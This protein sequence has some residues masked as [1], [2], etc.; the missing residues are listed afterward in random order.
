[1]YLCA[2]ARVCG[3]LENFTFFKVIQFFCFLGKR[4]KKTI[5]YTRHHFV[6]CQYLI[7]VE[8]GVKFTRNEVHEVCMKYLFEI[9]IKETVV[10]RH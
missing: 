4:R 1:M 3:N 5:T 6:L 2:R 10:P 7:C 8:K 9:L